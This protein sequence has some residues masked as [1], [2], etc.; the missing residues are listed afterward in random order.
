MKRCALFSCLLALWGVLLAPAQPMPQPSPGAAAAGLAPPR[1]IEYTRDVLPILS[2]NCFNCH[3]PASNARKA[4][5]RLDVREAAL[6]ELDSGTKAIVPGKVKESALVTRILATDHDRMPPK[7]TQKE[8][9]PV[10]KEI[11]KLWIE[12]GAEY[13]PHWAFIPPKMPAIPSVRNRSWV[14]NPID[15]FILARLEAE[16]LSPLPE[17]DRYTL[18]RRLAIDLTGLPPALELVERFVNDKSP[19]A[20]EK[21]VDAILAQPSYGERWATMWLDLARYADSNGYATDNLRT[22]WKYR[23]WVI[24]QFNNNMPFDQFTIE[25]LA[26]DLLP[27]PTTEQLLATAFHRNTLTNDEGGTDDEE[28]RTA[29]VVDRVTTTLQV[30]MGLTFNC[31]QCHDH[32]YDPFSQ[33][34]FYRLY[35]FFNQTEDAD[36]P[37]NSPT[38]PSATP[39]QLKEK[40]RLEGEIAETQKELDKPS[41]ELT[42]AFA[43]WL[44]T[45]KPEQLPGNLRP[46]LHTPREKRTPAQLAQLEKQFRATAPELKAA[47]ERLA[48]L[49]KQLKAIPI[50][51][52]PIMRELPPG[53]QRKTHILIRGDFLNKGKEVTPG[54][55]KLFHPL[56]KGEPANRLG[57]AKWLLDPANPLTARVMVNRFWD[58]VFGLGLVETVEDFGIRGKMPSHPELLD[59]LAVQF[60]TPAARGGLGWD[61]KKL[62][63]LMVTSATYRQSTR[64]TPEMLERDPNN[65]LLARGPRTRVPAEVIRDQALWSAGLLSPKMFGPPVR[66]PRPKLGLSAA[67]GGATDWEASPGEDKYRRALYTMVRRSAPYP[68]LNTFDAPDRNVCTVNRPRTNTPLQALVTLNDPVYVESAQALARRMVKEGGATVE[69]RIERGFRLAVTRPPQPAELSRL[70]QLYHQAR[71]RFAQ[72]QKDA[73]ALAT[74]PLGPL[75]P[76]MDPVDLAAYTLV[77]NVLLN[78]DELF[79]RR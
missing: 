33:E 46:I 52:T 38:L 76:G 14:R 20:Y 5:L 2:T 68:S 65:R 31:A 55:P 64:L 78:L 63:R 58:Q 37:D 66:P 54:V 35:A 72:N 16:G 56:P 43:K 10:E 23:D 7:S 79:A 42:K 77:G 48:A 50:V 57:L 3:G 24:D 69:S 41:P 34:E 1:K 60:Q 8:L 19:E 28:F 12:Q 26:G 40:A 4:G 75:P 62:I 6:K 73:E 67:F 27:H 11:L 61:M 25:Q 29:A 70:V 47:R 74:Q 36:R 51:Y 44:E 30:W 13:Q 22:I 18:A 9:K 71:A 39:D 53:K 15:A 17:A 49:Q 59:W 45:I 32:K 21:Y